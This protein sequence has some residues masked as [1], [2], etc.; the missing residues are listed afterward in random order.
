M[1]TVVTDPSAMK[2]FEIAPIGFDQALRRSRGRRPGTGERV[3][4]LGRLFVSRPARIGIIVVSRILGGLGGSFPRRFQVLV[5]VSPGRTTA[6]VIVKFNTAAP[7][8]ARPNNDTVAA[9]GWFGRRSARDCGSPGRLDPAAGA[10]E[11]QEDRVVAGDLLDGCADAEVCPRD[12]CSFPIAALHQWVVAQEQITANLPKSGS[13]RCES[14]RSD[15][16]R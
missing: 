14:R 7:S 1:P 8:L 6:P 11:K 16:Y 13:Q 9:L 3:R 12:A 5:R 15:Q 2:L 4:V 10:D